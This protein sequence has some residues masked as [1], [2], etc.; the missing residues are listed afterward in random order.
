M[1]GVSLYHSCLC[2]LNRI[3]MTGL[4]IAY[5]AIFANKRQS[6]SQFINVLSLHFET[7][8][9]NANYKES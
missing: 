4:L 2:S 8:G 9:N 5:E 7:F 3:H 6:Q 1:G